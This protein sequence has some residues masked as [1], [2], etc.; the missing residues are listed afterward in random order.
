MPQSASPQGVILLERSTTG[1][2]AEKAHAF[3]IVTP[4]RTYIVCAADDAE[5]DAWKAVG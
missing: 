3:E 1:N 5:R 4:L 2:N